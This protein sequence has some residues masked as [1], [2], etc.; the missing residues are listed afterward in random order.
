MDCL[1]HL[2]ADYC[3]YGEKQ[4]DAKIEE[5]IW[6]TEANY[7]EVIARIDYYLHSPLAPSWCAALGAGY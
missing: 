3:S 6:T 2:P 5:N 4:R 1:E 7:K